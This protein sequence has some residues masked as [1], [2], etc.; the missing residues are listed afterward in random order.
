MMVSDRTY[1]DA[2]LS[3]AFSRALAC[4]STRWLPKISRNALFGDGPDTFLVTTFDL[5]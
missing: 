4:L 5:Y 3:L 2:P 1:S